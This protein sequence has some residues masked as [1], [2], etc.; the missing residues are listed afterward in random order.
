MEIIVEKEEKERIERILEFAKSLNKEEA[1]DFEI[2]I[3]GYRLAKGTEIK[4][5][6]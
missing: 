1:R 2:L 5:S 3:K 4:K 6:A